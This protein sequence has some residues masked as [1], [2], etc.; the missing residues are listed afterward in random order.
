[1]K[2][3][4]KNFSFG[5]SVKEV[6]ITLKIATLE[7]LCKDLNIEFWQIGEQVKKN[8]FDFRLE[9]LW[10]GYITACKDRYEKPKYG[11]EKAVIWNE[12][13]SKEALKEFTKKTNNLYGDI[14]K[15]SGVKK[16]VKAK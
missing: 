12:Y 3:A 6:E 10:Q 8:D 7:A 2:L 5:F 13:L 1:M 15:M 14:S 4:F 16:K 9:L 11:K